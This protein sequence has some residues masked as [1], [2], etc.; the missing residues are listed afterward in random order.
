MTPAALDALSPEERHQIY[1]MLRLTV[2]VSPDGSL[3]VTGVLGDSFVSEHQDERLSGAK[4]PPCLR[5]QAN[6]KIVSIH[7]TIVP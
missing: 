3:N 1:K 7:A 5:H 2:E 6:I 4:H